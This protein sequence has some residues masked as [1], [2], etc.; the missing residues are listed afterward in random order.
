LLQFV[1]TN[2]IDTKGFAFGHNWKAGPNPDNPAIGAT[3][4]VCVESSAPDNVATD[5]FV[6]RDLEPEDAAYAVCTVAPE[7][8]SKC[9]AGLEAF[10]ESKHYHAVALPRYKLKT[11]DK[12]NN[13]NVY[14]FWLPIEAT[15]SSPGEQ[16]K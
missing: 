1:N 4:D 3:W 12:K 7:D 2:S 11:S 15:A 8:I 10:I 16:P 6:F 14:E 9:F 5:P 13:K